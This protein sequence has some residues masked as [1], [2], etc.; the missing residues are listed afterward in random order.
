MGPIVA[1]LAI[2]TAALLSSRWALVAFA[3]AAL[4]FVLGLAS[5]VA[6]TGRSGAAI[7]A[8]ARAT[9]A[10]LRRW[11]AIVLSLLAAYYVTTA[12]WPEPFTRLFPVV[13]PR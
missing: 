2:Y 6:L 5:I 8:R 4:S 1:S 10:M 9:A 3:V 12:A 7:R 11:S 13:P